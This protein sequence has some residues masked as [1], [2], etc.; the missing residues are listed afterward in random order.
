VHVDLLPLE[1]VAVLV[2]R[3]VPMGNL[4]P[5]AGVLTTVGVP[6]LSVALTVKLTIALDLPVSD[7]TW[8]SAG[9]TIVGRSISVTVMLKL[10]VTEFPLPSVARQVTT[11]VP[12]WKVEPEGGAQTSNACPEQLSAAEAL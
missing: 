10:F 7:G 8:I 5:E 6:Q 12:F 3:L 11:V 4:D 9:Q 2:T 1:S